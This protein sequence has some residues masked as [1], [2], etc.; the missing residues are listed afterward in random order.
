MCDQGRRCCV[1]KMILTRNRWP[2]PVQM[3]GFVPIS[4]QNKA[5]ITNSEATKPLEFILVR[6][7]LHV[8]C[9]Y[10]YVYACIHMCYM[11]VDG[12]DWVCL[13]AYG[14]QS[15]TSGVFNH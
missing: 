2:L 12:H 3:T 11:Y 9:V 14:G 10:I 6:I 13:H 1:A 4:L 15:L 5:D 7:L 8:T